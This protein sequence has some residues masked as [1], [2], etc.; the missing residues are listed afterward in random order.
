MEKG[1]NETVLLV[2]D[3]AEALATHREVLESLGYRVLTAAD[4]QEAVERY[5]ERQREIDVVILDVVMPRM[6]GKEAFEAIRLINP[7]AKIIF[8]TGYDRSNISGEVALNE[9]PIISKPFSV[10]E[11]SQTLHTLLKG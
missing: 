9:I 5:Q 3:H 1:G 2:D 10:G 6:G 8:A 4:G 11:L 7:D